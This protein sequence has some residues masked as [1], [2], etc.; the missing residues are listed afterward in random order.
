MELDGPGWA[1]R[2][3]CGGETR[4]RRRPR[5]GGGR[6]KEGCGKRASDY[7]AVRGGLAGRGGPRVGTGLR[8]AGWGAPACSVPRHL[9]ATGAAWPRGW[10]GAR[11]G[12]EAVGRPLHRTLLAGAAGPWH[13]HPP[14][15]HRPRPLAPGSRVA[16][17]VSRPFLLWPHS[18]FQGL[19]L[20]PHHLPCLQRKASKRAV[21]SPRKGAARSFCFPRPRRNQ[22]GGFLQ[23]IVPPA[24]ARG[25]HSQQV[26]WRSCPRSPCIPFPSC[27][28]KFF[29]SLFPKPISWALSLLL[30]VFRR[31]LCTRVP[32]TPLPRIASGL[33][34]P[35]CM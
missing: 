9:G 23:L 32:P 31:E 1:G 4:A 33:A 16:A 8:M 6:R 11:E 20:A 19:L 12:G 29:P 26:S 13:Q 21:L 18:A 14:T 17:V 35:K 27:A 7:H 24:L 10:V 34:H 25:V 30:P 15:A 5:E 3:A 28:L 22:W 2:T